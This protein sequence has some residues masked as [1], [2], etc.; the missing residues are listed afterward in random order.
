MTFLRMVYWKY[1]NNSFIQ[2]MHL[3]SAKKIYAEIIKEADCKAGDKIIDVG[4]GNGGLLGTFY[5]Q[6]GDQ[7]EY[8]GIEPDEKRLHEAQNVYKDTPLRFKRAVANHLP[9]VQD[10]YSHVICM[11]SFHHFPKAQWKE[12]LTELK[13]VLQPGGKLII[14]DF[15]R[16]RSVKGWFLWFMNT[17]K[18][19]VKGFQDFLKAE[20]PAEGLKLIEARQQFG[21]ITHYIYTK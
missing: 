5:H 14:A 18:G 12:S 7:L 10:Y 4:C 9:S 2:S 8:L 13:R 17:C 1:Q 21:Y 20:A 3:I 6:Y 19:L 11:V 16:P 15:G